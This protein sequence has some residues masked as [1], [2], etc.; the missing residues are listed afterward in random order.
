[1]LLDKSWRGLRSWLN[2]LAFGAMLALAAT[3]LT[4]QGA[5]AQ[6]MKA[7]GASGDHQ[8]P[9]KC[10]GPTFLVGFVVRSG[11]WVNELAIICSPVDG[12]GRTGAPWFGPLRGGNGGSPPHNV[13]CQVNEVAVGLIIHLTSDNRRVRG[14]GLDCK[15]A[16]DVQ[17]QGLGRIVELGRTDTAAISELCNPGN[18]VVE[19]A[20]NSGADVNGIGVTCGSGPKIAPPP[21]VTPPS[22]GPAASTLVVPTATSVSSPA[23][24]N[25]M[26]PGQVLAKDGCTP[27]AKVAPA[28]GDTD[29]PTAEG[30]I[31]CLIN[32]ERKAR[33]LSTL[34]IDP[35][36]QA[37]TVTEG[38][39]AVQIKWW[40][41][42]SPH[43]NPKT[44]AGMSVNAAIDSRVK[45]SGYCGGAN[46]IASDG[47]IAY[48]GAGTGNYSDDQGHATN[49]ACLIGCG[50]PVA[51]VDWWM[52]VSA[53]HRA[54][55]LTPGFTHLGV[56]ALGD[57]G[58]PNSSNPPAKGLYLVD[59]GS[60]H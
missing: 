46:K 50:T 24:I 17:R 59:F 10:Q 15:N 18:A 32:A 23:I 4:N 60:C 27:A 57:I 44:Q 13:T 8:S 12:S 22:P 29:S 33:G 42:S 3:A 54:L 41:Q 1:M 51:A 52:N 7:V 58:E 11:D 20:I 48:D 40:G 31:A 45:A 21:P 2:L 47:E 53:T 43:V 30:V 38:K 25:Q 56:A 6:S 26:L 19:V 14:I 5:R 37:A 55:I 49:I 28:Q 39:A 36:L 34:T 35:N 9:D 16:Q